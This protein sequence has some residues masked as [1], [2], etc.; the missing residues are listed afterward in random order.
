MKVLVNVISLFRLIAGAV[1]PYLVIREW[2]LA[3]LVLALV[4]LPS[5]ILDGALARRFKA[6]TRFGK[7]LDLTA[8]IAIDEGIVLGLVLVAQIGWL[9]ALVIG[10]AI[11]FVRIPGVIE[12]QGLLLKAAIL[13]SGPIWS[14]GLIWL[15]FSRYA[16]NALGKEGVY[17]LLA[18]AALAVPV[19][20]YLKRERIKRDA[21]RSWQMIRSFHGHG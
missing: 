9:P 10:I 2:W 15:M 21:F 4:A 11:V 12:P 18:T 13:V 6:E 1:V 5:D 7:F 16:L 14:L 3:A 20:V 8:D 17:Y 19:L